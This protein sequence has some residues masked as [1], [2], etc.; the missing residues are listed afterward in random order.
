V[1][2]AGSAAGAVSIA[3]TVRGGLPWLGHGDFVG[4]FDVAVGGDAGGYSG[5]LYG[6]ASIGAGPGS[7]LPLTTPFGLSRE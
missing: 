2:A 6:M 7:S 1:D 5:D 4:V 3:I